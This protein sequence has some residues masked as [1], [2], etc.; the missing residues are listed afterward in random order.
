MHYACHVYF[1]RFPKGEV[2][3]IAMMKPK[4]ATQH[5][6]GLLEY[7]EEIIGSDRFVSDAEE[8]AKAVEAC[9]EQRSEKV[10]TMRQHVVQN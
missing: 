6:E 3:Q 9:S 7:L 1:F 10:R 5:E 4:A 8:A 2:E